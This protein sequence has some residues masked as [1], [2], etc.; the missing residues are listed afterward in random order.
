VETQAR[1]PARATPHRMSSRGAVRA[2]ALVLV[3]TPIGNLGDISPRAVEALADA[4]VIYCEDTRRTRQLLTYVGVTG[5]RLVSLHE[6]NEAARVTSVLT[7]V[8]S[9]ETVAVV[10]DAG[11]PAVSDPG[12]RIVRAVADK[13]LVVTIVPGPSAAI[14]ALVVSGFETERFC[15]EGFLPRR[16]SARRR[17]LEVIATDPRTTV[18]FEAPPRLASTLVD[19]AAVCGGDRLLAV[20]RELTKVH[21][22]I[23]RGSLDQAVE[24]FSSRAVR[25]EIAVVIEGSPETPRADDEEVREAL[26][27]RLEQ[28]ASLRDA[29][30]EVAD[31]LAVSRR[32]AYQLALD[33]RAE[34]SR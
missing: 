9:G 25:G 30:A 23:W 20:A 32:H 1:G 5:K 31:R 24:E 33:V 4:D 10:S 19:L 8:S 29:A 2:G 12:L 26:R 15:V 7:R 16:G 34:G 18:I 13:G 28:G 6:H 21:E 11:T 22:E 14:A 27:S 3:A 17:R